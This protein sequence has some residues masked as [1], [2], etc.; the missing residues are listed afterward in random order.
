MKGIFEEKIG[1]WA[2]ERIFRIKM[3]PRFLQTGKETLSSITEMPEIDQGV[4][5]QFQAKMMKANAFKPDEK[6]FKLIFPGKDP[7]NGFKPFLKDLVTVK[8]LSSSLCFLSVP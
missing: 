3:L 1:F 6:P 5:N 8:P 7:F 2:K 4:S